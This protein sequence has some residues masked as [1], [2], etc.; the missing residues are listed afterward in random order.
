MIGRDRPRLMK[1]F[2]PAGCHRIPRRADDTHKEFMENDPMTTDGRSPMHGSCECG[3]CAFEVR[4]TPAARFICHCTICQAYTGKPFSDVAVLRAK[5]VRLTNADQISAKKYRL[6][7]NINRGLCRK[8]GK[9]PVEFGGFGPF[10]MAFIPTSNFECQDVLPKAQMHVFYHRRLKDS[11]D[12]LPKHSGYLRSELGIGRMLM[13][14]FLLS[15]SPA[16]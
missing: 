4:A 15:S 14:S 10:R 16:R 1:A 5:D 8:C 6:P 12:S 2:P 7:P 3:T 9:P 13:R 11:Q